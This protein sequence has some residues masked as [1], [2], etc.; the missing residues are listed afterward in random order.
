MSRA[1]ILLHSTRWKG[2]DAMVAFLEDA[3]CPNRPAA[4]ERA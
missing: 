4:Q 3:A 1:A 2:V